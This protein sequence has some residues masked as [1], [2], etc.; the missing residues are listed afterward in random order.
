MGHVVV[1]EDVGGLRFVHLQAGQAL[2]H[3]QDEVVGVVFAP[4]PFIEAQ[5]ALLRNGFCGRTVEDGLAVLG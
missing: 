1:I 2:V 3:M 4:A 5:V